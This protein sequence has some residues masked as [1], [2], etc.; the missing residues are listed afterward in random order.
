MLMTSAVKRKELP[1]GGGA[2]GG[3]NEI[4]ILS[5]AAIEYPG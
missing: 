2:G 4:R 3:R 5:R 1:G